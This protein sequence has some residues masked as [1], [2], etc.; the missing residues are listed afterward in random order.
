MNRY[1]KPIRNGAIGFILTFSVYWIA[2][3]LWWEFFPY[4]TANVAI[5]IAVNNQFDQV[6]RGEELEMTL[7]IDKQSYYTPVVSRN[8]LCGD[9]IY[10]VDSPFGGGSA[11]PSGIYTATT[12]YRLPDRIPSDVPC[13]FIFINEYKVNPIRTITKTWA[14]EPFT[15]KE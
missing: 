12:S 6:Q 13:T 4:Q 1:I 14:S 8:V 3:L 11:R 2:Q 15:I 9:Q 7:I 10:L 5:P